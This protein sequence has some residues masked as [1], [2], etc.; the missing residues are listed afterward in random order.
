ME[1]SH[2]L[3]GGA[4]SLPERDQ[5]VLN[6]INL[7]Q[8]LSAYV[9]SLL[10]DD[11]T[12][13]DVL[14]RT[15]V[16]LLEKRDDY[17]PN[18]NFAAWAFRIAYYEVLAARRDRQRERL[19]FDDKTLASLAV[20]GEAAVLKSDDR[21]DALLECL[22]RLT[23][24]DRQLVLDR[25]QSGNSVQTLAADLHKTPGAVSNLL[26]RIRSRLLECVRRKTDNAPH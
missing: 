24:D 4:R 16:V 17:R 12:T 2:D 11:E 20:A 14:Q 6:I 19:L 3:A 9:Y 15:N 25:Y 10:L 7:Q 13:R 8:R 5:F 1:N 26:Y 18:S 22:E 21:L 23:D